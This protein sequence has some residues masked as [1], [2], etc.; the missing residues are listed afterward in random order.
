LKRILEDCQ[1]RFV[2]GAGPFWGKARKLLSEDHATAPQWIHWTEVPTAPGY[3]I[4]LYHRSEVAYL[5]YTSGST[6]QPKGVRITHANVLSNLRYIDSGFRH[7]KDSVIL[8]WLPQ[9]HD[10]GLVYGALQPVYQGV[11][12]VLM[13]PA[14]F[15]QNPMR[16][17]RLIQSH[18]AT[19]SGG[20]NFAY[21]LCL[22][23]S[24]SEARASLDLS[25]WRVAFSGGEAV[26][27]E[28]VKRFADAFACAGFRKE[29]FCAAYGLAEATLKVSGGMPGE[30]QFCTAPGIGSHLTSGDGQGKRTLVGCG[31]ASE[32]TTALI[33]DPDTLAPCVDGRAGEIWIAGPGVASGYWNRPRETEQIFCA[34]L[35]DGRGPFLRSGDIGFFNASELFVAG[36][37]KDL[38]IIHGENHYP[39][40]IELTVEQT[41]AD[42][43]AG[44]GAAFSVDGEFGERLVIVFEVRRKRRSQFEEMAREIRAAVFN[45]HGITA[46]AIVLVAPGGVPKTTSGKIQRQAARQAYLDNELKAVF[47]DLANEEDPG[48]IAAGA[49]INRESLMG[50]SNENKVRLIGEYARRAV[51]RLLKRDPASVTL[52]HPLLQAGLDS[53]GAAQLKALIEIDLGVPAS[54]TSLLT[55]GTIQEIATHIVD[56]MNRTPSA[57]PKGDPGAS[58][59]T[60]LLS[61]GQKALWYL[62]RTSP[63]SVAYNVARALRF[64]GPVD[65][66]ILADSVTRLLERHASLRSTFHDRAGQPERRVPAPSPDSFVTEDLS[67]WGDQRLRDRLNEET[68]RPFTLEQGPLFRVR[69]FLTGTHSPVLLIVAHHIVVDYWS[70]LIFL[71]ELGRVYDA[72]ASGS[73]LELPPLTEDYS[74]Y[75]VWQADMVGGAEGERHLNYWRGQLERE[76]PPLDIPGSRPRP[77]LPAYHGDCARYQFSPELSSAIKSFANRRGATVHQVLLAAYQT[78]LHRYTGQP[79]IAVGCPALARGRPEFSPVVGYFVNPIVV[80]ADFSRDPTFEAV[81]RETGAGVLRALEH[82]DYPFAA[83]VERL[84]PARASDRSPVFQAAFVYYGGA[85]ENDPDWPGFAIGNSGARLDLGTLE[86]TSIPVHTGA[87]QFDLTMAMAD[88]AGS[89]CG[90]IEYDNELFD[91]DF[92]AHIVDHWRVLIEAAITYPNRAVSCLPMSCEAEKAAFSNS[93]RTAREYPRP[94]T[95][96]E[97]FERQVEDDPNAIAIVFEDSRLTRLEL[98]QRSNLLAWKLMRSGVGPEVNVA[99]FAQRSMELVIG[100]LAILKAGGVYVPIDPESPAAWIDGILRETR[101][102][103]ALTQERLATRLPVSTAKVVLL[104]SETSSPSDDDA[105]SPPVRVKEDNLAYIIYT[106][107]STGRPKGVMNTHLGLF[108]RIAWMAENYLTSPADVILHKTPF[109]FDVSVWELLLPLYAGAAMVIARPDGHSDPWYLRELI[110]RRGVTILHFVPSMLKA[111]LTHC[112]GKDCKSVKQ[113][114]SSGEAL[115]GALEALFFERFDAQLHNLYG[116]TE[117]AI[118]VTYWKCSPNAGSAGVPIGLP[119]ANTEIHVL[120]RGGNPVPAGIAGELCI[121]GVGLARGYLARPDLSAELFVPDPFRAGRRLYKTGDLARRRTDG[122]IEFLGR[123]DH[124]LKIHGFRIEPGQIESA[125]AEHSAVKNCAVI[126]APGPAGGSQLIAYVATDDRSVTPETLRAF[127]ESRLPLYMSPQRFLTMASLPLTSSGKIDRGALAK[128]PLPSATAPRSEPRGRVEET[129]ARIWRE[130]LKAPEVGVEDN[131]FELGGDSILSLQVTAMAATA[132]IKMRPSDIRQYQTISSLARVVEPDVQFDSYQIAAPGAV[133]QT[134]IQRWFYD[135]NPVDVNLFSQYVEFRAQRRVDPRLL[136]RA[137]QALAGVH[138]A[139][140]CRFFGPTA[141]ELELAAPPGPIVAHV[142]LSTLGRDDQEA[143]RSWLAT[144]I[145]RTIDVSKGRLISAV[146]CDLSRRAPQ[147]V[148]VSIHHFAVDGVSWRILLEDLD[149]IYAALSSEAGSTTPLQAASWC[150]WARNVTGPSPGDG[151][152]RYWIEQS[153]PCEP[154]PVDFAGE[155]TMQ[156]ADAVCYSLDVIQTESLRRQSFDAFRA[157]IDEVLLTAALDALSRWHAGPAMLIE[158]ER[159]GRDDER[160]PEVARMVGWFTSLF[161]LRFDLRT[162]GREERLRYVKERVRSVPGG[163]RGYL[164]ARYPALDRPAVELSTALKPE[165]LF[166]YLG[167]FDL[168]SSESLFG[169]GLFSAGLCREGLHRRSYLLEILARVTGGSLSIEITYSRNVHRRETVDAFGRDML[170][171]LLRFLSETSTG[172]QA[173]SATDF[174]AAQLD[175]RQ[176]ESLIRQLR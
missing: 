100:L 57:P 72:A 113:V 17:L 123:A 173:C 33:V 45:A 65:A 48:T 31:A 94:H 126:P 84:H 98:N 59:R 39:E 162:Q 66:A 20:P 176:L 157:G 82:Q 50:A 96:Q 58:D 138:D 8:S 159:H 12:G 119:I 14:A 133:P 41:S 6:A 79:L 81:W 103:V 93:N 115:T 69:L 30:F 10:M 54:L 144:A 117:A 175:S 67:G 148:V 109:T 61:Y 16:W 1:P 164:R 4:A 122:V 77:A 156:S 70:L 51:A 60:A 83:L 146:V 130:V 161:P 89:I 37:R 160:L 55:G 62:H 18:R 150:R 141:C 49:P 167:A 27:S 99:L 121:G 163:G 2:L 137:M 29:A 86:F 102:A 142:D 9:F 110:L 170:E 43:Q 44:C 134:P 53:L 38:L 118:D 154:L 90:S 106:S 128:S 120:D 108:N 21:Q 26:R 75:A 64:S 19:H 129:L 13:S 36:R 46:Q 171:V 165:I 127:V 124:Q 114:F 152:L 32:G 76:L 132:G 166:N 101:C 71:K 107:G 88:C 34:R 136:D 87:S 131:F 15:V 42:I 92:A 111:F 153:T 155:N 149:H 105:S 24:Q 22:L 143:V 174:P 52:D 35:A 140:R 56:A 95:I 169:A 151:E 63:D 40:D 47:C 158:I 68:R 11:R 7:D 147:S 104:E 5:Q 112:N 3:P 125:L 135:Q 116:P 74:D 139:L 145:T 91:A 28:T 85:R 97:R 25:A 80:C 172:L 78:L 23:N 73:R 168:P